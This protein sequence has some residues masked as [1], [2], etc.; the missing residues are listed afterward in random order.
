MR[1]LLSSCTAQLRLKQL[2]L[3]RFAA[4]LWIIIDFPG[5]ALEDC[6][7][8]PSLSA[9]KEASFTS[10][11]RKQWKLYEVLL[12]KSLKP[13]RQAGN[14]TAGECLSVRRRQTVDDFL[15]CLSSLILQVSTCRHGWDSKSCMK[16]TEKTEKEL[17]SD[18]SET[19]GRLR[20]KDKPTVV[21]SISK[22]FPWGPFL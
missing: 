18:F 20:W 22:A 13:Q 16:V 21:Y 17:C 15:W 6:G 11:C 5:A 2:E 8:V 14:F 9:H 7:Q 1:S 19:Q 4:F 3:K 10:L 12:R